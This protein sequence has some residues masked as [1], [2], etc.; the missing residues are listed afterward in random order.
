MKA[1]A[2]GDGKGWMRVSMLHGISLT[3]TSKYVNG[4]H[5]DR[6]TDGNPRRKRPRQGP[7]PSQAPGHCHQGEQGEMEKG[8]KTR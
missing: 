7:N 6:P 4:G 1:L 8:W 2:E 5:D 3:L